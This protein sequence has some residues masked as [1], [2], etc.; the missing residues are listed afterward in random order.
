MTA[1]FHDEKNILLPNPLTKNT[2]DFYDIHNI[3]SILK[4]TIILKGSRDLIKR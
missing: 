1:N 2:I 4:I 3:N